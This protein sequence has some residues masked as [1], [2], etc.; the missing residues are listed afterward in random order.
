MPIKIRMSPLSK[1]VFR[2]SKQRN[3]CLCYPYISPLFRTVIRAEIVLAGTEFAGAGQQLLAKDA[4]TEGARCL[5]SACLPVSFHIPPRT[6]PAPPC[7]LAFTPGPSSGDPITTIAA[8]EA[9]RPIEP[10]YYTIEE[11]RQ[12]DGGNPGVPIFLLCRENIFDVSSREDLYGI[13]GPQ[14]HAG[15]DASRI[16]AKMARKGQ[17]TESVSLDDLTETEWKT[18]GQWEDR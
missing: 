7:P 5:V 18:L 11:I 8:A 16:L 14:L 2:I 4:A 12:F 17:E 6:P 9:F 1:I 10:R 13:S 3:L 15:R